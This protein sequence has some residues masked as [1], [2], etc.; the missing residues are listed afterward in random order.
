M[1]N[2]TDLTKKVFLLKEQFLA[3]ELTIS[4]LKSELGKLNKDFL[5]LPKNLAADV[6]NRLIA[7]AH[8]KQRFM[9]AQHIQHIY[10][11]LENRG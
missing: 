7:L 1:T 9:V 11:L 2:L 4:Q 8:D 10:F 6:E 5:N 3:D